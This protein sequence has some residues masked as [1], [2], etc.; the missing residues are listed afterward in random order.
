[1]VDDL[2]GALNNIADKDVRIGSRFNIEQLLKEEMEAGWD[3]VAVVICGPAA[4]CDDTRAA[5]A[6]AARRGKTEFELKVEAYS[7]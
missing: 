3:R 1:L 6:T 4:L 2:Q 7:W 5:V